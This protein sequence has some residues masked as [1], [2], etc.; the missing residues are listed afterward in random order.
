MAS[1]FVSRGLIAALGALGLV[2]AMAPSGRAQSPAQPPVILTLT[3][4]EAP[5]TVSRMV[6]ALS[7]EGRQ[8]EIRIAGTAP[9]KAGTAA[10]KPEPKAVAA[11]ETAETTIDA[12]VDHIVEGIDYGTASV[13]HIGELGQDWERAWLANRNGTTGPSASTRIGLIILLALAVAGTFRVASASWFRR[14]MQ[15]ASETFT[16]RLVASS[17]GLLQ[18]GAT[19]LL[20]LMLARL[21]R[22][23]WLPEAD[24]ASI[25][26]TTL[27][28]G[29]AIGAVYAAVGRFLLAPGADQRR[30]MPMPRAERH[31]K[32]LLVYAVVTPVIIV[33]LLLAGRVGSGPHPL[34]GLLLLSGLVALLFKLWWFHDMRRDLA[35]LIL[36]G[37]D[38]PGPWR[39]LIALA[40]PW[41]YMATAVVLW[42]VG[43]AAAMMSDGGRWA[44]AA[45]ITQTAIVIIPIIAVGIGSFVDCRAAR[46]AVT[47]GATP[48]SKAAGA[49]FRAAAVG[50]LW[51]AGFYVVARLWAGLLVGMSTAQFGT[52]SRQA[53][54]VAV[55]AFAGW[56]ALVFLRV[57]FDAC[58]PKR[59][60]SGPME[61]EE[62]GH[63]D[64][65]PS[66]LATV[67]P[68][69]RGVVLGAVLGL[70]ILIVLSRLGVDIGPLLAGFGILGLALSFGSQALVRDIVS[71][72]F[73]ML[74]DAFRVGEY[75]DTGR[76]KGTVEKI[77]LRSMQL[78]H[79]SGQIHT[80]P[81]GQIQQ[82][83]NASRDWATI[84]FNVRLDHSADI[85]Q[86]RK[87]IKKVGLAL[88]DDPEFGPHF[89]AQL[90][91]QGVA[92]ITDS[93]VVIRLK[94]TAKPAQASTLQR[95]ALKRVYR[96]LNEAKVPFASNAVTVR[97]GEGSSTSGAAAIAAVPPPS[98]LAPAAG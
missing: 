48:L 82:L 3:G 35:A 50:V 39:R 4:Q 19:I 51:A 98:P 42:A 64:S 54:G 84:K 80:I 97:G 69:L 62:E 9:A 96:A 31:F 59:R 25:A 79:Q 57:F 92:D 89:I 40:A 5:D 60:A 75:V 41:F 15:P 83:T 28:N 49:A 34:A 52:V 86:A 18:D 66:R 46:R 11:A 81:F 10:S 67:L 12:L 37:S 68:V 7:R 21:C 36:G 14:R 45:A 47:T 2:L 93:A 90:K 24:L 61:E 72:V 76:L 29:A 27:A 56:V 20:A 88:L 55:F 17:W 23:L 1:G 65:V 73:F 8:V 32:L 94:F 71:G 58:A 26:L 87:T 78:R 91:M 16:A 95:E 38:S 33:V 85:E 6:E 44:E 30:L 43:R 77:S 13:P 53:A 63:A 74:E 70:T 22:N